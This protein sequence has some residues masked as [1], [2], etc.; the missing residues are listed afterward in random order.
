MKPRK[1][2][3]QETR[4][5]KEKMA[6]ETKGFSCD[7]YWQFI[8]QNAKQALKTTGRSMPKTRAC[9]VSR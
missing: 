5:I 6:K 2:W 1:D 7:A 3:L 4:E 9:Q 8:D